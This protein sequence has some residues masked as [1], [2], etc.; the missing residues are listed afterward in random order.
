MCK[1][2]Q[3]YAIKEKKQGFYRLIEKGKLNVK[4]CVDELNMTEAEILDEMEKEGYKIPAI[5]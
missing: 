2:V 5:A 1:V 3:D 4:D